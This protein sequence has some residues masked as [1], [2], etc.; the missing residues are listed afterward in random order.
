MEDAVSKLKISLLIN[1]FI[2]YIILHVILGIIYKNAE[3]NK[4]I[5]NKKSLQLYNI[6]KIIFKWFPFM[7]AIFILCKWI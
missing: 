6:S 4:C 3:N 2:M 1:Y 7:Y 5:N